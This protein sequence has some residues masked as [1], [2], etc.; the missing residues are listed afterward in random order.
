M[1]FTVE[2]QKIASRYLAKEDIAIDAT[3]GN[4]FDT[5]FLAEQV[6]TKGIVYGIDIQERAI[7]VARQKLEDAG[8]LAQCRLV[9]NSHSNLISIV[10]SI[11]MKRVSVVMFN[12]GY[13]PFGDKSLVTSPDST[14][15]ALGHSMEYVRPGG[16]ISVLAYPGHAGGREES[17]VVKDWIEQRS[18]ALKVERFQDIKN[19]NSPILWALTVQ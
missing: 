11:H 2:A 17:N 15:A 5:L 16:L 6:G 13:L 8:L 9:A 3:C 1:H 19:D 18:D 14:L 12:L 4:G 10:D 7:E